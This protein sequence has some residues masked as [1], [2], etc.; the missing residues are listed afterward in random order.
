[1]LQ[2]DT[3][4]NIML[5]PVDRKEVVVTGK[6]ENT[7]N[8]S[9]IDI[10]PELISKLPTLSGEAD[11]FKILQMLPGVKAANELSSG[12]YIRGGSPDQNLT[13]V[14]GMNIYNPSHIGNIA[15]TFNSGAVQDMRLIKGAFPSEYGGRISG[16]LDV[17]LRAGTKEKEK[18]TIGLGLINSFF[19]VE[20]P[21]SKNS[22]YMVSGRGMYYDRFQAECKS[23]K[24]CPQV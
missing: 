12:L 19:T 16:I 14:D 1:M 2:S 23:R 21:V 20:G 24:S 5:T 17:K 8:I 15:S 18:G 13:L 6:K 9:S 3:R 22:T 7:S 11:I 10:S 4:I